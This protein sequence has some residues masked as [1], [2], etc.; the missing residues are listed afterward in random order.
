MCVSSC[1]KGPAE[2]E[3]SW[4]PGA[5]H[6]RPIVVLLLRIVAAIAVLGTACTSADESVTARETA[7]TAPPEHT[8]QDVPSDGHSIV[9]RA[10]IVPS[11]T[12]APPGVVVVG[13]GRVLELQ[14]W[15][16]CWTNYC[17]D[18][19]PPAVLELIEDDHALLVEFP[20]DGWEFE[21]RSQAAGD[22]C[23]RSQ[24]VALVRIHPT[25]FRLDPFGLAGDHDITL[26]GRG[27]GGDLFVSFRWTTSVDGVLPVPEATLSILADHD[28]EVDSYGSELLVQGL[29]ST[30]EGTGASVV[31]TAASGA[32]HEIEFE[33]P[34][35]GCQPD[36]SIWLTAPDSEGLAAAALGEPPFTYD[37]ELRIDDAVHRAQAIWPADED[38]ECAPCVPLRFD[39]PLP[40]MTA[41][42]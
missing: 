17:A 32:S 30:P 40:A 24:S 27:P 18:G 3:T 1:T 39:P 22:P 34:G 23:S 19:M 33:A 31:V 7:P 5:R 12:E 41:P 9:T 14:P 2:R 20:V 15:T 13:G 38:E 29:G 21:A 36:G 16:T 26:F 42:A 37:V 8:P 25:V 4:E 11:D 35:A 28:G 10:L 6:E